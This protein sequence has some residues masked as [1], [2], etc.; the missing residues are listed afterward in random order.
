MIS[1]MK[2]NKFKKSLLTIFIFS[3]LIF[4]FFYQA[5]DSKVKNYASKTAR[6]Y[7]SNNIEKD[8]IL[9]KLV[10]NKSSKNTFHFNNLEKDIEKTVY[11]KIADTIKSIKK[12]EFEEK[13]ENYFLKFE[14]SNIDIPGK[15]EE[16]MKVLEKACIAYL[17][18]TK[19]L[20]F[21]DGGFSYGCNIVNGKYTYTFSLNTLKKYARETDFLYEDITFFIKKINELVNL[22]KNIKTNA[23]GIS[24]FNS[25]FLKIKFIHDWMI[26]HNSYNKKA[27]EDPNLFQSRLS[28]SP[29]SALKDEYSPVC[30]GYAELA[31]IIFNMFDIENIYVVGKAAG[32]NHAWNYVKINGKFYLLD[33]TH[34]DPILA[35]ETDL[36]KV[37]LNV[38]SKYFLTTNKAN[39]IPDSKY[40]YPILSNTDYI[41]TKDNGLNFL[42]YKEDITIDNYKDIFKGLVSNN[43]YDIEIYKD[44]V[45]KYDSIDKIKPEAGRYTWYLIS[46]LDR[47]FFSNVLSSGTFI[48]KAPN[49]VF[50]F[51][52]PVHLTKPNITS[53]DGK[54]VEFNSYPDIHVE[55]IDKPYNEIVKN[56]TIQNI[57]GYKFLYY[58]VSDKNGNELFKLYKN[59]FNKLLDYNLVANLKEIKFTPVYDDIKVSLKYKEATLKEAQFVDD[60]LSFNF[61]ML[62]MGK[63]VKAFYLE[64][65]P[66]KFQY[67]KIYENKFYQ[68]EAIFPVFSDVMIK[69]SYFYQEG[70]ILFLNR[71]NTNDG[72]IINFVNYNIENAEISRV[73]IKNKTDDIIKIDIQIKNKALK[74]KT[75]NIPFDIKLVDL[76]INII[77]E[78]G[79]EIPH[80]FYDKVPSFDDLKKYVFKYPLKKLH[81][82]YDFKNKNKKNE[83]KEGDTI[84]I[85]YK[86]IRLLKASSIE[87]DG[88]TF[89][90]NKLITDLKL[91]DFKLDDNLLIKDFKILKK[92]S[93][94][95]EGIIRFY[96]N[97]PFYNTT[98]EYD[99][100]YK[101]KDKLDN[102]DLSKLPIKK[103]LIYAIPTFVGLVLLSVLISYIVKKEKSKRT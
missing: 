36:N 8:Y 88:N 58:N 61:E 30:E 63:M 25:D 12:L 70:N 43:L 67:E 41:K 7:N 17:S 103:I 92:S 49:K 82:I 44:G 37:K 90:S 4:A 87:P 66:D 21:L 23:F 86:V 27:L 22:V 19:E 46:K 97:S 102:T 74:N 42:S 35:D 76:K 94:N 29:I 100:I 14:I 40:N 5:K 45:L 39:H 81:Q 51:E 91:T 89:K 50:K 55:N 3:L 78:N 48:I 64:S 34:D 20:F 80:N 38:S 93:D 98:Q 60:L 9:K 84:I 16:K 68:D 32:D 47:T 52:K 33:I 10:I 18:D 56:D 24:K 11:K 73:V 28:H 77:D 53:Y 59:D 62:E 6:T 13:K 95:K 1:M 96:I 79:E 101:Y 31:N 2:I 71:K 83:I 26:Y 57:N 15:D 54:M 69:S 75:E 99:M 65:D 72:Q 85:S